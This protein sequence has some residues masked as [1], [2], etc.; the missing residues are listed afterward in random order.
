M[1]LS[2][3]VKNNLL[4][5]LD[6]LKL[7]QPKTKE[8]LKILKNLPCKNESSLIAL[9]KIDKNIILSAR[10]IPKVETMSAKDLNCLDLLTSKY[11]VMSKES[12]KIINETFLGSKKE[13]RD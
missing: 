3:K 1:V 9:P 13:G 11:L 4:V 5:L 8:F 2:G 10:N 12:I 6:E 7:A